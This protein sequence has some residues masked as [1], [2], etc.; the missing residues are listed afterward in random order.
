MITTS[1]DE[2]GKVIGYCEWRRVGQSGFDVLNGPYIYV[3]DIWI[4]KDYRGMGFLIKL[5]DKI[6]V[7]SPGAVACYFTHKKYGDRMSRLWK[8]EK[9]ER[10]VEVINGIN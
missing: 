10:R 5:I 7:L 1:K 4:H 6:L 9:F 2:N 3:A 8:R